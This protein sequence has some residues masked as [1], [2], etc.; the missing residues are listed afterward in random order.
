MREGEV[1]FVRHVGQ[2][3][4]IDKGN[5]KVELPD[6]ACESRIKGTNEYQLHV[7]VEQ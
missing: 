6:K 5:L 7:L 4:Y 3:K 2:V 1:G